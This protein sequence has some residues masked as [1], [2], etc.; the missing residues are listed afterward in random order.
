MAEPL[1][2]HA[3]HC[4]STIDG[5]ITP[6]AKPGGTSATVLAEVP[7][8]VTVSEN[9]IATKLK[10]N[11]YTKA[12]AM[13]TNGFQVISLNPSGMSMNGMTYSKTSSV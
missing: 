1:R 9:P 8:L 12:R 11:V 6:H 3:Q 13:D 10:K 5:A 7:S 4:H 2:W